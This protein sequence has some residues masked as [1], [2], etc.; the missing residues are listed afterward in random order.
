MLFCCFCYSPNGFTQQWR[1]F[2]ETDKIQS[3]SI[4]GFG[5]VKTG[6][7][8]FGL[9]ENNAP[10]TFKISVLT[11][12]VWSSLGLDQQYFNGKKVCMFLY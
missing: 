3:G 1:I 10:Y 4:V 2:K 9:T 5:Q 11:D 12:T 8:W 7:Y 6:D